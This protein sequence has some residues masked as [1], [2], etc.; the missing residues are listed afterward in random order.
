[1]ERESEIHPKA[2][3]VV[4]PE[5][6]Q[7]SIEE[8]QNRIIYLRGVQVILDR[9]LA[10]IYHVDVG[11]MNRQVKNNI[12]RFPVDFMFQLTKEE[13]DALKCKKCI[14]NTRGGDHRPRDVTAMIYTMRI[15]N[16]FQLD[17]EKHNEQYPPIPVQVFAKSHDR[18]L[19]IDDWVY[20]IGASLK[21]LGKRWFAF[22]LL[23]E[24]NPDDLLSRL[25]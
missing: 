4:E 23:E 16:Q 17:I 22:S 25:V 3:P 2:N 8:V 24:T 21:D 9:E 13:R 7:V 12:S 14:S 1:M 5:V 10:K 15:S 19:L 20:H 11:Y 18:F 6:F